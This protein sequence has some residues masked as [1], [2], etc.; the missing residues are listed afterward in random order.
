MK[1]RSISREEIEARVARF[2]DLKRLK[3]QDPDVYPLEAIDIV[4]ARELLPVI[5]IESNNE[6]GELS[7]FIR[8]RQKT[9]AR[10]WMLIEPLC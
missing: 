3:N 7:C 5:G 8:P 9:V 1:T 6:E 10:K 4:F 2:G